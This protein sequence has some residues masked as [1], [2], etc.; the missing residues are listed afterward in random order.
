MTH[1]AM[2]TG[3]LDNEQ[4]IK[5]G[6][7]GAQFDTLRFKFN[8]VPQD[9]SL[10]KEN[11]VWRVLLHPV[12]FEKDVMPLELHGDTIVGVQRKNGPQVDVDLTAWQ[13]YKFGVSRRHLRFRPTSSKLFVVDLDSTNGTHVNGLPIGP[14]WA[15]SLSTGD[16][17][18]LGLLNV[19]VTLLAHPQ[20]A[21]FPYGGE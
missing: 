15:H 21:Y 1:T 3:Q 5:A 18:T 10:W 8:T 6:L 16:V 19:R 9:K 2:L 17:L 12:D 14:S 20:T 13:A 7:R 4:I 11:V